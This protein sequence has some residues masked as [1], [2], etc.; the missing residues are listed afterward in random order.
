MY[1]RKSYGEWIADV[2]RAAEQVVAARG[3]PDDEARTL[4]WDALPVLERE[5]GTFHP[6]VGDAL[7]DLAAIHRRRGD[8]AEAAML[9][10]RVLAI[11][12]DGVLQPS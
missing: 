6:E 12:G 5:L 9:E 10:E 11:R 1:P 7:A 2:E 4:L 3:V 8:D